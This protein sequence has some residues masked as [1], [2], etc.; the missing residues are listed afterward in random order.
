MKYFSIKELCNSTTAKKKGI[1]NT[2]TPEAEA[3]LVRLIEEV[4]D[5]IREQD[6]KPISVSSGYRC[7]E[8]NSAVGGAKNS[9]HKTGCAADIHCKTN[10]CTRKVFEIAKTIG[11]YTE[12][13]Y[14]RSGSAIW[15][16]ISWDPNS[17]K[18]Y[19]CDNYIVK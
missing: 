4:L 9:F 2:P 3:N 8:L 11:K 1:D 16:H 13:L 5:P 15:V 18:H 7:E 19:C 10:S 12:L 6:G 17:S 14:E